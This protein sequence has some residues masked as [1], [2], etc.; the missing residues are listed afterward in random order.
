MKWALGWS[1][2]VVLSASTVLYA[3]VSF[4]LPS[5]IVVGTSMLSLGALGRWVDFYDERR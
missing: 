3:T 5:E 4:S 2:V 1:S